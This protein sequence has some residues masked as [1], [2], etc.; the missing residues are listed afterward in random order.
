MA[1]NEESRQLEIAAEI[2]ELSRTLV[3]STRDVPSPRDS[4]ALLGELVATV[5]HLE[6]VAGQLAAWH[7]RTEDGTHYDG[8]DGDGTGGAVAAAERLKA[9]QALLSEASAAI[10]QAHSLNGVVRW[11]PEAH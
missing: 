6:Q 10:S 2:E 9:A 4:Y 11:Y 5:D 1:V 8:E 7:A 3:H